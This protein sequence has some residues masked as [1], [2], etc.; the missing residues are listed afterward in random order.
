M[1]SSHRARF[2]KRGLV[3]AIGAASGI[4]L[5][6][7]L[8]QAATA[9]PTAVPA[10]VPAVPAPPVSQV[11]KP[12]LPLAVPQVNRTVP[13]TPP[14][15]QVVPAPVRQAV[16]APVTQQLPPPPVPPVATPVTPP[17]V[18]GQVGLP[19]AGTGATVTVGTGAG[20]P[21]SASVNT[22][23]GSATVTDPSGA[24]VPPGSAGAPA[25]ASVSLPTGALPGWSSSPYA[26]S[27]LDPAGVA[28]PGELVG[29]ASPLSNPGAVAA[30]GIPAGG[31]AVGSLSA[32]LSEA[33]F[34]TS[35]SASVNPGASTD[36]GQGTPM[37]CPELVFAPLVAGCETLFNP[38]TG[39]VPGLAS[40][41]LPILSG[42]AGLLLIAIGC[43]LYRRSRPSAEVATAAVAGPRRASGRRS[44][45]LRS[46]GADSGLVTGRG[47]RR[48]RSL[49]PR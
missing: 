20:A 45:Q 34:G 39:K 15:T 30:L 3:A 32:G 17:T 8:A 25:G 11:P 23:V 38:V 6:T 18:S 9:V 43:L 40:T 41:G 1:N 14:V 44:R 48:G 27:A 36:T 46:A 42:L 16:P 22:P 26:S 37:V 31:E 47:S 49:A 21:A 7:V 29:G 13:V 4:A 2:F 5:Q 33:A 28:I 10:A 19:P 35:L 24:G 12:A